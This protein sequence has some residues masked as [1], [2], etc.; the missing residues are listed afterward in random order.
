VTTS[1][2]FD[3][4]SRTV[5]VNPAPFYKELREEA[6]CYYSEDADVWLLSRYDDVRQAIRDHQ[7]FTN[8][9]GGGYCRSI[10]QNLLAGS[11]PPLHTAIR[12]TVQPYLVR[13][14]AAQWEALSAEIARDLITAAL[15]SEVIDWNR[16]FAHAL[17]IAVVAKTMGLSMTP[18]SAERFARWSEAAI[19]RQDARSLESLST[20]ATASLS[21]ALSWW[22]EVVAARRA[23]NRET[24]DLLD[25][26]IVA[27]DGLCSDA[28]TGH[29]AFSLLAGGIETT[30]HLLCRALIAFSEIPQ[31]WL[32]LRQSPHLASNVVDEVLR[33]HPPAATVF[34]TAV[35]EVE[36]AGSLI[37]KGARVGLLIGSANR[38]ER[39][40]PNP[41]EFDIN[42]DA[43]DHLSFGLGIHRCIGEFVAKAEAVVAL[44]HL[45]SR[46]STVE[47]LHP[48]VWRYTDSARRIGRMQVRLRI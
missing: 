41:D 47:I 14:H 34:R 10:Q 36:I 43:R 18:E 22:A 5:Y 38:D 20:S 26:A 4:F 28:A 37:P 23:D 27:A 15:A 17:P 12:R 42:R 3:L 44:A 39:H 32:H 31:T 30:S 25:A 1:V 7:N 21:D 8:L 9:E 11:D 2:A 48:I 45:A 46:V 40:Y 35:N 6:P 19:E 29:L 33:M 24:L 13:R 16:D